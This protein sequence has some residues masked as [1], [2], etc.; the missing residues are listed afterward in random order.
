M[1]L[2]THWI[3]SWIAALLCEQ[4]HGPDPEQALTHIPVG[5]VQEPARAWLPFRALLSAQLQPTR[6]VPSTCSA[7]SAPSPP[8]DRAPQLWEGF[9]GWVAMETPQFS[10]SE[11]PSPSPG[12]RAGAEHGTGVGAV[13]VSV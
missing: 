13:S 8:S 10:I 3:V 1:L 9:P 4:I 7:H 2:I 5:A 6:R 12:L 11:L